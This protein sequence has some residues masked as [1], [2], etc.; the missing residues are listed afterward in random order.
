MSERKRV[1][2]WSRIES[3][4]RHQIE[5]GEHK[6]GGMLPSEPALAE[7]FGVSRMT[8]REAIGGLVADGLLRKSQGKGTFVL[9]REDHEEPPRQVTAYVHDVAINDAF[10]ALS[11]DPTNR[12]PRCSHIAL[13]TVQTPPDVRR[14][15]D[16]AED[17]I[18]RVERI[19][20]SKARPLAYVLDYL[21]HE[22]G[23]RITRRDL[24]RAWLTQLVVETLGIPL[25]EARQTIEATL[26][27]GVLAE[28]LDVG[29][30]SPLLRAERVYIGADNRPLYRATVWH[31]ADRFK[32]ST[33]FRFR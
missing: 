9:S 3:V 14:E 29:F 31:R 5:T 30:G 27:D 20:T 16:Y 2:H 32:Y 22:I 23:D 13:T 17:T 24:G 6:P 25:V 12:R 1:P 10:P 15:L 21:P 33:V 7:V 8:I 11:P 4:L 28:K 18:V 26:A 19:T